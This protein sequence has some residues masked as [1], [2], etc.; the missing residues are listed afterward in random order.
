MFIN[1]VSHCIINI[2][3]DVI[4]GHIKKTMLVSN[5]L[6]KYIFSMETGDSTFFFLMLPLNI[7]LMKISKLCI[8]FFLKVIWNK[9]FLIMR[10]GENQL[11][12]LFVILI[13]NLLLCTIT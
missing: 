13:K 10:I 11:A 3:A 7:I 9:I 2:F 8:N 5:I 12:G 6:Q 1:I 4:D